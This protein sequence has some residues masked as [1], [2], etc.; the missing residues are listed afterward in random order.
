MEEFNNNQI[1]YMQHNINPVSHVKP[2]NC[3]NFKIPKLNTYLKQVIYF[4]L[5][6]LELSDFLFKVVVMIKKNSRF[7]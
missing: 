6:N 7:N 1:K 2:F 4:F 3:K 5:S